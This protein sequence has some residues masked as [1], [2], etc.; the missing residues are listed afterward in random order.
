M[1]GDYRYIIKTNDIWRKGIINN[2]ISEL[3]KNS[4]NL[5][6]VLL[7]RKEEEINGYIA[8][9]CYFNMHISM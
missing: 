2:L 4:K 7:L 5:N 3:R 9:L 1:S 8:V 6:S